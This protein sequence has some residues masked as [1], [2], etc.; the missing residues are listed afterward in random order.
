[1]GSSTIIDI[2]FSVV[3]AGIILVMIINLNQNT[4]YSTYTTTNDLV[5]QT[6]MTELVRMIEK[7]FRRIGYCKDPDKI[8]DASQAIISADAHSFKFK[9]DVNEDASVDTVYYYVGDTSTC[10]KTPNP[11]DFMIYRKIN[12]GAPQAML[13]G[14]TKFDFQYW[15]A[16]ADP[17]AIP[18]GSSSGIIS[19]QLSILLESPYAYDTAYSYSYWRQL[20]LAARNLK[21]R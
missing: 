20:R 1:M 10:R 12:S 7:D 2:I 9:T 11:R 8:P 15:N 13:L 14:C 18:A 3:L 17:V 21:S 4:A 19:L 16:Q 5:I 6:N